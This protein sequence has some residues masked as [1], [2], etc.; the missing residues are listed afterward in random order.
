MSSWI[1]VRLVSAEP[2]QELQRQVYLQGNV[3]PRLLMVSKESV[4]GKGS[5][6][7]PCPPPPHT[8]LLIHHPH[9][10]IKE[11]GRS[12]LEAKDMF[13]SPT[14]TFL[15]VLTSLPWSGRDGL[16]FLLASLLPPTPKQELKRPGVGW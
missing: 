10:E 3:F 14:W 5:H 11:R 15:L 4:L 2:Q 13:I 1:L 6:G 16:L 12:W 9:V 7:P 8:S